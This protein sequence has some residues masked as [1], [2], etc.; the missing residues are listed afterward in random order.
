MRERK[1]LMGDETKLQ[2]LKDRL[3]GRGE[4]RCE[5]IEHVK[6]TH[7]VVYFSTPMEIGFINP[8]IHTPWPQHLPKNF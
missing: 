4:G 2:Q 5:K 8:R 1:V 3:E 6:Q 7:G